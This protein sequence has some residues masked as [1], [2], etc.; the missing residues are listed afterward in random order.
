MRRFGIVIFFYS[1]VIGVVQAQ[2]NATLPAQKVSFEFSQMAAADS[3]LLR[4]NS[5]AIL[6]GFGS[7]L[8]QVVLQGELNLS[9]IPSPSLKYSTTHLRVYLNDELMGVINPDASLIGQAQSFKINLDGS[10]FKNYNQ[11]KFELVGRLGEACSVAT[12]PAMWWQISPRSSL[13]LTVQPLTVANELSLLPA[14]FFDERDFQSSEIAMVFAE[15]FSLPN[16][17]SS[18]VVASYFASFADWRKLTYKVYRQQLPDSHAIILATNSQRPDIPISWPD[19]TL[20][21]VKMISHPFAPSRKILLVLGKDEAQLQQAAKALIVAK[22]LM[23]GDVALINSL[24][25]LPPRQAYDAPNWMPTNKEVLLSEMIQGDYQLKAKGVFLPAIELDFDLPPDLLVS[26]GDEITVDLHYRH[27]L[28]TEKNNSRL[29]VF[30]NDKFVDSTIL[31]TEQTVAR[32][33]F[34][35]PLVTEQQAISQSLI[36]TSRLRVNNRLKFD[37]NIASTSTGVCTGADAL[38]LHAAIDPISSLKFPDL[39]HYIEMPNLKVFVESGFPYSKMADLSETAL[40]INPQPTNK[41]IELLLNTIA[42][43]S[44]KTGLATY[45]FTL[46]NDWQNVLLQDKDVIA[47][48]IGAASVYKQALSISHIDEQGFFTDQVHK[49]QA[50]LNES[51][52]I[53]ASQLTQGLFAAISSVESTRSPMRTVVL[54]SAIDND[55]IELLNQALNE[56]SMTVDGAAVAIT[57]YQVTSFLSPDSYYLGQL[58]WFK[59]VKYHFN[60][61]PMFFLLI[62][63]LLILSV[64]ILLW[65][66]LS[67]VAQK[68]LS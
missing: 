21:T 8:D 26:T 15:N 22:R 44:K 56:R 57:P 37:F 34:E 27:S 16:L 32:K 43:L 60:E 6:V 50:P 28:I 19:V 25:E 40:V 12:D 49:L 39:P 11:L 20:P 63:F 36:N 48:G 24:Q 30:V 3:L 13:E 38:D 18:A 29:N 67:K 64:T 66:I 33:F 2:V 23:T 45:R 5:S 55:S 47:L 31:E 54:L 53:T 59:L 35:L 62:T 7:R 14:P 52:P 58:S 4:G 68:R 17:H 65:L 46:V 51:L 1:L 41:E 61:Q 9:F 42:L 10:Y